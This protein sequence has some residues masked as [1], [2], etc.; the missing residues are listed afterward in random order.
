MPRERDRI[1]VRPVTPDRWTDLVELF[2]RRGAVSGCWCMWW[3]LSAKDWE[4]NA[5][6]G[7]RRSMKRLVDS[8]EIPGL[9]AYRDE[10]PLGWVSV[11]PREQ[12]SRIERSRT[13][14]PVDDESVWSIVCFYIDRKERASGVATALL[15]AAV[16][17]A[18]ARGARIV[19]AYPVD[20][21]E[22]TSNASAFT[23][24]AE[25]FKRAGFREVARRR[26]ARPI[27]RRRVRSACPRRASRG[28]AR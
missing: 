7:N 24:L 3:R 8:G 20:P 1:D 18:A 12:F 5:Y 23:G 25:M 26:P 10:R 13:L 17:S 2:G 21:N 11:A 16:R 19:E 14:G 15:D 22:G 4:R 9:L 28:S 27:M 6:D